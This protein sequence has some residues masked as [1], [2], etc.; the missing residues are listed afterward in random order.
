MRMLEY[1]D[2]ESHHDPLKSGFGFAVIITIG[3]SRE[4]HR[5]LGLALWIFGAAGK[6]SIIAR[7]KKT[8]I[9]RYS[10][11]PLFMNAIGSRRAYLGYG[12]PS[13]EYS[14]FSSTS[15]LASLFPKQV[16]CNSILT[17]TF[18]SPPLSSPPVLSTPILAGTT[19][20]LDLFP[21]RTPEYLMVPPGP[22][23]WYIIND[24]QH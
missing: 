14:V 7:V 5:A 17:P 1:A 6:E 21:Y 24:R 9:T 8:D 19:K 11:M 10:E 15:Q 18:L 13:T 16:I 3:D 23:G 12:A 20:P 4:V 22:Y 2:Q